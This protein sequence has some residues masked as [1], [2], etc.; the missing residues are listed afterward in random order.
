MRV[1]CPGSADN[2]VFYDANKVVV[3]YI[4]NIAG[5]TTYT[6]TV[7]GYMRL[8]N[9]PSRIPTADTYVRVTNAEYPS[10]MDLQGQITA[11]DDKTV[12]LLSGVDYTYNFEWTDN[13]YIN[14][15]GGISSNANYIYT[16]N[17]YP[18]IPGAVLDVNLYAVGASD[19]AITFY[20]AS[21]V[22]L[23]PRV[24]TYGGQITVPQDAAFMRC[25]NNITHIP[26][27]EAY[28]KSHVQDVPNLTYF[29]LD[30]ETDD[31]L[32]ETVKTTYVSTPVI[33]KTYEGNINRQKRFLAIGFDDLRNTDLDMIMPLFEKYRARATFNAVFKDYVATPV[34]N[35]NLKRVF[36]GG[37]ELGDH[38]FLH[39]SFP[40]FEPLY[41]GQNP[42]SPDG[43]QTAFP[44]NDD[45]RLDVGDGKNAFG[46]A[47]TENVNIGGVSGVTWANLTDEQ[48][49][50]IRE[51]FSVM[52]HTGLITI[53]DALSNK[54][55]GTSG[56][57]N[58]SWDSATGKYTGGI[59]T[60]CETS[61]NH[62]VWERILEC[63][64]AYIRN[65]HGINWDMYTWSRP[66]AGQANLRYAYDGESYYDGNHEYIASPQSR[67]VSSL[68][69][70]SRSWTDVLLAFGYKVSHDYPKSYDASYNW[71][72]R[73]FIFNASL[74]KRDAI[75]IP[76]T[77]SVSYSTI[78]S[79]YPASFFSG[80]KSKA[81][82]MY[83]VNGSFRTIIEK[84]R[85]DTANGMI[86]GEM[87]DSQDNYSFR[88][89]FENLLRYCE[90]AGIEVITKAEAYDICFN[91]YIEH[92][93][94]LGNP[95]L[96]NSAAEFITDSENMP[97]NPDGY[98]GDCSV[99]SEDGVPVLTTTGVTEC[100]VFGVPFGNL[101]YTAEAKGSG[102]IRVYGLPN[103]GKM[104]ASNSR[105]VMLMNQTINS[106]ESYT[107]QDVTFTVPKAALTAYEPVYEGYADRIMGVK[108]VYSAGLNVKNIRLVKD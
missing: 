87:I 59:Y 102:F 43:A 45:F 107:A 66:G 48:C 46:K 13:G 78:A 12:G 17:Y 99:S 74:S 9:S 56:N 15:T 73:Q 28:V 19:V 90:S 47:L 57:S 62:E 76:V 72:S 82:Q 61:A 2:I 64:H 71:I 25:S 44:S 86:H 30:R 1:Y 83:D 101:R 49:Q 16:A 20:N 29:N 36:L 26:K 88:V 6:V 53:L 108:I 75:S 80:T 24:Y 67:F 35:A 85:Q 54:Y 5:S 92:G 94:L 10:I 50:T 58:G 4:N 14:S 37:H 79:A 105:F 31:I 97:T 77:T 32:G 96:V 7:D 104:D 91:N 39:L 70:K 8:S 55:L 18:V 103:S 60:G 89:F 11:N 69:G 63:V 42:A 34:G 21:K 22:A 106:E 38:T 68:T 81:A 52:K 40:F 100:L 65:E 98:T 93:N 23:S 33:R 84:I 51:A 3:G 41:N 95:Y 27:T